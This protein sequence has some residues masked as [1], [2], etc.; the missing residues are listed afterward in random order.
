MSTRTAAVNK[1]GRVSE[2]GEKLSPRTRL[3]GT[4]NGA[5]AVENSSAA[6][7]KLHGITQG[8]S[9]PTPRYMLREMK[10]DVHKQTGTRN[11]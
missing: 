9:N 1:T 11:S 7:Q 5:A 8:P 2:D 10:I 6:T 3:V 4:E